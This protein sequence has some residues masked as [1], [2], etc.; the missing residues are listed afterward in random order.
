MSFWAKYTSP[1]KSQSNFLCRI[2]VLLLFG[3]QKVH[4]P[5]PSSNFAKKLEQSIYHSI[6]L[7]NTLI[8]NTSDT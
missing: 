6:S 2:E 5:L 1:T 4:Q 7:T 3:F 8:I